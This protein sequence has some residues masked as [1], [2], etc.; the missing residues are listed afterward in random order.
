M[1]RLHSSRRVPELH[2]GATNR[3]EQPAPENTHDKDIPRCLARSLV[4]VL[5]A[6]PTPEVQ[7]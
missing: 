5:A 7:P 4:E 2:A 6:E 1:Q 3:H